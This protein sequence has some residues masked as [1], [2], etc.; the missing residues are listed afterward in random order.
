MTILLLIRTVFIREM[1]HGRISLNSVLLLLLVSFVSQFRLELMYIIPHHKYQVKPHLSQWF[2][3]AFATVIFHRNQVFVCTNRTNLLTLKENSDRLVI[4]A[5]GFLK[6]LNL[7]MQIK[8]KMTQVSLYLF[9]FL[10]LISNCIILMLGM[11]Y[12]ETGL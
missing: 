5:N 9:S 8:Q 3:V 2:S 6:L 1:F 11:I 7:H 12:C 4:V 10:G